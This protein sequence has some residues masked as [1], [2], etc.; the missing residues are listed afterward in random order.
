MM[1]EWMYTVQVD[2]DPE[3]E[4][5]WND[6]Y[7]NVHVPEMVECPGWISGRRYVTEDEG[8]RHYISVYLLEGPEAL[9]SDE[10]HER[11]G[12]GRFGDRLTYTTRLYEPAG[13][14][15]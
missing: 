14:A 4:A 8:G 5:E 13:A 15:V 1:G 7:D 3:V 10:F 6:W 11:R 2:V 9:A 12:W